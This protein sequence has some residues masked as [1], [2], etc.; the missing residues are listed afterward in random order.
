[1]PG[2]GL[3]SQLLGCR[4]SE[5]GRFIS[6]ITASA[7]TWPSPCVSVSSSSSKDTRL[8]STQMASLNLVICRGSVS[9]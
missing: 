5:A 8:G 3:A 9:K 6:P 1:M 2:V 7:V 4:Q